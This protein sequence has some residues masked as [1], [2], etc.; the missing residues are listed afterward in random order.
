MSKTKQTPKQKIDALIESNLHLAK[1]YA[2]QIHNYGKLGIE[3]EDI[4]QEMQMVV[5][6]STYQWL[7][8]VALH[9]GGESPYKPVPIE[10]YLRNCLKN[11][12]IE[13]FKQ[14]KNVVST[15]LSIEEINFDVGINDHNQHSLDTDIDINKCRFVLHGYDLAKHFTTKERIA[16]SRLLKDEDK[17]LVNDSI[18]RQYGVKNVV[19]RIMEKKDAVFASIR[20]QIEL[21]NHSLYTVWKYDDE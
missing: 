4:V 2:R 21:D 11:K 8:K 14:V 15:K 12:K 18:E 7:E 17:D 20:S 10:P 9:K 16:L 1:H 5:V 13:F 6:T 19:G 3:F